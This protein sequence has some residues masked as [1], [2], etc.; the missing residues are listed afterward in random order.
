MGWPLT[1]GD[2]RR[3][4]AGA[5]GAQVFPNRAESPDYSVGQAERG[6][7]LFDPYARLQD[8]REEDEVPGR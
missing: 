8:R 1:A 4:A 6:Y 7:D 2:T 5:V 3:N